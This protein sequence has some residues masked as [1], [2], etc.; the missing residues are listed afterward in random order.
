MK[1]IRYILG[2]LALLS[3]LSAC[4]DYLDPKVTTPYGDEYAYT[5]AETVEGFLTNAYS[6]ISGQIDHYSGDF[7]DAATGDAVTNQYGSSIYALGAGK[8]SSSSN[9]VG[10]WDA[11]YTAFQW[12]HLFQEKSA[13]T[14]TV[15][16]WI[17]NEVN[18][19][20]ERRRLMGESYFLRAFWGMELLRVYGGVASNNE[21]LGY[22]I[23]TE[24]ISDDEKD[25]VLNWGRNTYEE[26]VQQILDD[27]DSA[28]AIL[29][30]EYSDVTAPEG[31]TTILGKAHIGRATAA[32]AYVLKSRVATY[33]ASP[34]YN[35][36]ND[37]SKWERAA[38]L[39][40]EAI[41]MVGLSYT[42]LSYT[43]VTNPTLNSTPSDYVFRRYH[44]NNSL[45]NRNLP[46]AY[47][48]SGRTNP[49]QNLVNAFPDK[50]GYPITQSTLYDPQDPYANRDPRLKN[51]V[52]YNG[53]EVETGGRGLEV[54][55]EI[56]EYVILKADTTE[57]DD[58]FGNLVLQIDTIA[59]TIITR[60][61]LDAESSDYR[62]TRTGY[63]LRK[64]ISNKANMIDDINQKLNGQHMYP[65]LRGAEV[66]HNL[67]EASFEATGSLTGV[68]AGCSLSAYDILSEIRMKNLLL[69]VDPYLD[70]LSDEDDI[71]ALIRNERRLEFA[72]ENMR[73][74]DMRRWKMPL[75]ET[76]YGMKVTQDIDGNYIYEGTDPTADNTDFIVEERPFTDQYW[77]H[78]LP[79]DELVKSSNLLNNIGW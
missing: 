6:A 77:Y 51:T 67:A 24:F 18:D 63:Y 72:F 12:I 33:A 38:V 20:T 58:G 27:C 8:M 29:P 62:A 69:F 11:A 28:I 66:Y 1:T 52:I 44:N 35:I 70:G 74:F 45:E 34:A 42:A 26:C 56:T 71:R 4:D 59:D 36:T 10:T 25:D 39:S 37:L 22:P 64:W 48:G 23:V 3:L 40:Q 49:S 16:W 68:V 2:L 30:M 47:W 43:A 78:P 57:V 14:A 46:P 76:V 60:K 53:V 65:I 7:L 73:Y 17:S 55:D 9:P 54:A 79:Y 50:D 75:E 13:D 21:V 5:N 31:L 41:D 61:G 32:A 19:S 15:K